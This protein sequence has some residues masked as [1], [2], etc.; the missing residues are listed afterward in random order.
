MAN[1]SIRGGSN[2]FG[3]LFNP[4]FDLCPHCEGGLCRVASEEGRVFPCS[5]G[6]FQGCTIYIRMKSGGGVGG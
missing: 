2:K 5:G 3:A 1:G 4:Q 6:Q